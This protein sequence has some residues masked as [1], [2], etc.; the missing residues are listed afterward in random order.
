MFCENT[1]DSWFGYLLRKSLKSQTQLHRSTTSKPHLLYEGQKSKRSLEAKLGKFAQFL[2]GCKSSSDPPPPGYFYL[3]NL[4][5]SCTVGL[6]V[7]QATI[8]GFVKPLVFFKH[9]D[10][11]TER[12]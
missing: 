7:F 10:K 8:K 2:F 4:E 3:C 9:Q 5:K 1:M 11:K 6:F 12:A